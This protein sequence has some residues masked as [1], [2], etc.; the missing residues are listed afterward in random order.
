MINET[1]IENLAAQIHKIWAR[2][3]L[4][5]NQNATPQNIHRWTILAHTDYDQLPETE[6]AKDRAILQELL[7]VISDNQ[8]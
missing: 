1:D 6:K 4:H 5:Y 2:W 8:V 7:S 3:F